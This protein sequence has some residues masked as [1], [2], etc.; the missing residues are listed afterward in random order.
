[1]DPIGHK[2]RRDRKLYTRLVFWLGI[3]CAL[4]W[5][6]ADAA[7]VVTE[8]NHVFHM[9]FTSSMFCEVNESDARAALKVWIM[10]V[11]RERK[12]AVDP[13]LR[14]YA[15]IDELM[16]ACR[17]N[18]VDGVGLVTAEYARLKQVMKFDRLGVGDYGGHLMT[19]EYLLLVR[20]DSGVE[21]LDQLQGRTINV[22][23]S[24]RTSLATIWLD[25]VLLE[26]RLKRATNFFKHIN[27]NNN[28][29]LVALPV[30]FHQI[31][32]CLT[33]RNSF[34]VM[35]ELNPQLTKQLRVL[36]A[37][38]EVVPSCFAFRADGASSSRQQIL[39]EMAR[40]DETPAGKQILTL[41]KADR[42]V[43]VP[44]SSMDSSLELLA[45]HERLC[46]ATTA[47]EQGK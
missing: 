4:A 18:E 14:I 9:A 29:S 44:V 5:P 19:E 24:P 8:T 31:D 41:V 42:I 22:L 39:S 13:D 38:P 3:G 6:G 34:K 27:Y 46:G 1:M 26:A 45:R 2:Q 37:S 11:A 47:E 33:T 23:N 17:T 21:R 10:T 7:P 15:T 40:L 12:I 16:A 25:T 28:A 43:E 30:F 35:G 32:A 20:Q 36:A